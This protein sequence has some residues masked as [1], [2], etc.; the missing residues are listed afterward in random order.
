MNL[1]PHQQRGHDEAWRLIDDGAKS[2]AV[3]SPTGGGK[4]RMMCEDIKRAVMRHWRVQL[5]GNR[6][7]L[8]DQLIETLREQGIHF[9]V[10]SATHKELVRLT[11][12][13][14][15]SS[16]QT[17]VQRIYKQKRWQMHDARLVLVDEAHLQKT[18]EAERLLGDHIANGATIL[19]YTATPLEISHRYDHLVVAGTNTELRKC[20]AHL[21]CAVYACDEMDA[22]K[23]KRTKTGEFV[24]NDIK[25]EIWTPAVVGRIIVHHTRLNPELLAAVGFAPGVPEARGLAEE[26][27]KAGIRAA[28][29]DGEKIWIDGVELPA[30]Q[31][32][33]DFLRDESERGQLPIVWCRFVLREGIDW[34]WLYHCVLA[35]PIGSLLSYVQA[36]GRLLRNHPSLDHV[37]LQDH[38]GNWWRHGSPNADR[39]WRAYW[40]TPTRVATELRLD[41]IREK[42]EPEPINCPSCGAVRLTGAVC[43]KC[44]QTSSR[45]S[46][47]IIQHDGQLREVT[48]DIL[49]PRRVARKA[50]TED[51]WRSMYH[52]MKRAGKTFRQAEG[53][54]FRENFYYPPRDIALMPKNDIDFYSVIRDVPASQ[55]VKKQE[56]QLTLS[57][58]W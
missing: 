55:L 28:S 42:K 19:G 48:G 44:G 4:S 40:E 32:N 11:E 38:G 17:D 50:N 14:Q 3:T 27:T 36:V 7:M 39:D 34:P 8:I 21:P 54:F 13:V 51:K 35:T 41:R 47:T 23:C 53:L 5:Y 20:G 25:R 2:I 18:G 37:I 22:S 58:G 30:N 12:D 43:H 31:E 29:I 10:R 56:P 1:W 9:G 45:K 46:R 24:Y 33:R 16:M 57:E 49:K 15:I 26:Y 6:V 52:R